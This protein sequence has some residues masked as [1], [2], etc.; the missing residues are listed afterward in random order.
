MKITAIIVAAGASFLAP[1][2]AVAQS[3]DGASFIYA[4][5]YHCN[6]ATVE[7][8]DEAV[9]SQYSMGLN[10]MVTDGSVKSWGWLR[11]SVGGE[12][13]R[14]GFLIGSSVQTLLKATSKSGVLSDGHPPVKRFEEACNSGEDYVWHVLAGSGSNPGR[15][16]ASFSTYFVCDQERERQADAL[17]E[18]VIGPIYEK[19]VTD[20][21]LLAWT[22]AEHVIGGKYRRF[23]MITAKSTA[24]LIAA[25][26]A[27]VAATEHD[28]LA[29]VLTSICATHQDMIWEVKDRGGT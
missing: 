12:W 22:W 5:Y 2:L 4:T 16:T 27:I 14:A 18:R 13:S 17:V 23:A 3:K 29:E 9:S 15:G 21:R 26:E 1:I 10:G 28:P 24:D 20:G 11:K 7:Q 25:R 6:S 8:A 19:L